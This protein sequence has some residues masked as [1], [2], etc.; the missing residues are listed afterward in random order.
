MRGAAIDP[1]AQQLACREAFRS[2]RHHHGS[3][4]TYPGFDPLLALL[5]TGATRAAADWIEQWEVEAMGHGQYAGFWRGQPVE[6]VRFL[7]PHRH[8]FLA[9]DR[10]VALRRDCPVPGTA[11]TVLE[12]V[13]A[14]SP[15]LG[16]LVRI[17]DDEITVL[18]RV[19]G[20]R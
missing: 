12:E 19:E 1:T 15:R 7:R 17:E 14:W 20:G 16:H 6:R 3:R 9:N 13:R 5:R 11:H 8:A 18:D 2:W 10:A 4:L